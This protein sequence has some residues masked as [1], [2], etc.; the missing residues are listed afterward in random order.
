MLRWATQVLNQMTSRSVQ[1]LFAQLTADS[2]YTSPTQ[3]WPFSS[4]PHLIHGSLGPPES[5]SQTASWSLHPFLH[6]S[7]SWQTDH[8]TPSVTIVRIYTVLR[9]ALN[10]FL[11]VFTHLAFYI[12]LCCMWLTGS[13][14]APNKCYQWKGRSCLL[15]SEIRGFS[16]DFGEIRVYRSLVINS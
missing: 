11:S 8:A 12:C 5:T 1:P 9:C 3:N 14:S 2:P 6:G 16:H 4:G 13:N 15:W 7:W 10:F